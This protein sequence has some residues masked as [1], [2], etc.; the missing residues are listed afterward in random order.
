MSDEGIKPIAVATRLN[1]LLMDAPSIAELLS[2][3]VRIL[4][5][6]A[7]ALADQGYAMRDDQVVTVMALIN[8]LM[9]PHSSGSGQL[10]AVLNEMTGEVLHV[11]RADR[12]SLPSS[13]ILALQETHEALTELPD[14][15]TL[16]P[17]RYTAIGF[18]VEEK[19]GSN[20]SN[21][22]LQGQNGKLLC[23]GDDRG[24]A[25]EGVLGGSQWCDVQV[26]GHACLPSQGSGPA[27]SQEPD[28]LESQ[29]EAGKSRALW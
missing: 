27:R 5:E 17:D 18:I 8:L 3:H 12:R 19:N 24:S 4:K 14:G 23:S 28:P 1:E 6:E 13:R 2:A 10:C 16:P 7:T 26:Q 29:A 21:Q 20:E 11:I 25:P 9:P 15:V 22:P